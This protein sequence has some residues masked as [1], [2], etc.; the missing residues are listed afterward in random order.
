MAG[1][2]NVRVLFYYVP[3]FSHLCSGPGNHIIVIRC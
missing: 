3:M 1:F 2:G